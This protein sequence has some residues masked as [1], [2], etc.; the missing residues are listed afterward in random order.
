MESEAL[1]FN[2]RLYQ[3]DLSCLI[4]ED[5]CWAALKEKSILVTGAS[6]LI[7]AFLIDVLMK[8][9]EIFHDAIEIYAMARNRDKLEARFGHYRDRQNFHI[10]VQDV[11]SEFCLMDRKYDYMIHAASNTHPREYASDPVGTI[12]TNIFGICH[13]LEYARRNQNCRVIVLSSVEVYGKNRGDVAYFEEEYCGYINC[14]TL[15]AGYPE[16][17]RLSE[18]LLQAYIE[19]YQVDGVIM[20]LSRTYGPTIAPDDSKA[21]SQFIRNA[22]SGEDII[23]KSKGDQV[24]SYNYVADTIGA[25]LRGMTDGLCGEAYNV[26]DQASDISLKSVAEYLAE[27]AGTKVVYRLPEESERRGYSTATMALMNSEKIRK[28]G[29]K[30]RYSMQEGLTRTLLILKEEGYQ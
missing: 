23:L 27:T 9:N 3:E 30:A 24:Y 12:T 26:A 21:I 28:L 14:N 29:W 19:Q 25:I 5:I 17:K 18:A 22:V 15:R 4:Q 16:S 1:Y 11:S 10:L 6:G 7:G 2:H 20:R 8:R 13:L